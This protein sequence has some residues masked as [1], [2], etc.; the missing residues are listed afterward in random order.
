MGSIMGNVMSNR[1]GNV[2]ET[3]LTMTENE[4]GQPTKLMKT[5]ERV[6]WI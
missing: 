3:C 4:N 1:M 6:C 2:V 5:S